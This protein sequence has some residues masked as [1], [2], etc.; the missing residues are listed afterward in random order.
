MGPIGDRFFVVQHGAG[1]LCSSPR[2]TTCKAMYPQSP[3]Q[4]FRQSPGRTG[5]RSGQAGPRSPCQAR[6]RAPCD[7]RTST[8]CRR[9]Q[10]ICPDSSP[11][12][13]IR[14]RNGPTMT[15][16]KATMKDNEKT[17]KTLKDIEMAVKAVHTA[18]A[19]NR[20]K[21]AQRCLSPGP[22]GESSPAT[23]RSAANSA[24]LNSRSLAA[25][26]LAKQCQA[27]QSQYSQEGSRSPRALPG[28]GDDP[29]GNSRRSLAD[30]R[31][32]HK[33]NK[34]A[35]ERSVSYC[36]GLLAKLDDMQKIAVAQISV[37]KAQ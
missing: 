11:T 12:L 9:S 16:L 15:G 37:A 23:A 18:L 21:L 24:Q 1:N 36:G 20:A 31:D 35:V 28:P 3:V 8:A 17:E 4:S 32:Q 25:A 26:R 33:I 13:P 19:C 7:T 29:L 30:A 6:A 27:K 2:G 34:Q 14:R 22:P 5:T 10:S